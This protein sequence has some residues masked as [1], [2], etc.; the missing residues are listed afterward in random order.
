MM[1]RVKLRV[2]NMI[3]HN[4]Y[5]HTASFSPVHVASDIATDP[6][7]TEMR[8][9]LML[10]TPGTG[11]KFNSFPRLSRIVEF[12]FHGTGSMPFAYITNR[13]T[14]CKGLS[15]AAPTSSP[16][17]ALKW[18]WLNLE[19]LLQLNL[20]NQRNWKKGVEIG[21]INEISIIA[22]VPRVIWTFFQDFN[23][24]FERSTTHPGT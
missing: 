23:L 17:L 3:V 6:L 10:N 21:D 7:R 2:R 19:V 13:R 24:I 9:K 20:H 1:K 11:P 18:A 22:M 16:S 4:V 15:N 5:T 14:I 8:D 12:V